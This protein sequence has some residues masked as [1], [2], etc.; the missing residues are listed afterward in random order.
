MRIS[1]Q[2]NSIS[3]INPYA[4]FKMLGMI[5]EVSKVNLTGIIIRTALNHY[6]KLER[7]AIQIEKTYPCIHNLS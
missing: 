2:A 3:S 4:E 1:P 5:I 7:F 6:W